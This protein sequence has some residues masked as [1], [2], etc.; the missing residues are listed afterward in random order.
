MMAQRS[1][2]VQANPCIYIATSPSGKSYVG[3]TVNF[4]KRWRQHRAEASKRRR[5]FPFYEAL[6]KYGD[7]NFL[8]EVAFCERS[9]LDIFERLM[10]AV[11]RG[12]G[13]VYNVASGGEG[14]R[15]LRRRH[16]PETRA[17]LASVQRGRKHPL[18]Q[19]ARH[20]EAMRGRKQSPEHIARKIASMLGHKISGETRAKIA[21][22][23]HGK[24]RTPECRE[25][26]RTANL[27][28][29]QS[30]QTIEKRVAQF[31]GQRREFFAEWRANMSA[32]AKRRRRKA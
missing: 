19:N 20:A 23:N 10:I 29:K 6:R 8:I 15:G 27:G 4:E 32:A 26:I 13:N 16:S 2:T 12:I 28:K 17:K 3:Q 30:A 7:D 11:F 9:E 18:E 22:A 1:D 31:R 21:H 14:V 5:R 24:V 25:K